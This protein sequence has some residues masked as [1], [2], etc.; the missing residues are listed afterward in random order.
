MKWRI[1]SGISI[2]SGF[3]IL[4][5]GLPIFLKW[6]PP[7]AGQQ[8]I[9]RALFVAVG[10]VAFAALLICFGRFCLKK[11]KNELP[12]KQDPCLHPKW[13]NLIVEMCR[14]GAEAIN[15]DQCEDC[16][17]HRLSWWWPKDSSDSKMGSQMLI[18]NSVA[19]RFKATRDWTKRQEIFESLFKA[20]EDGT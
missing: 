11:S 1:W 6:F 8:E 14:D 4:L 3:F 5:A 7:P 9:K 2:G 17:Q 15:L 16:G 10:E 19:R 13:S 20:G 18:S 12:L